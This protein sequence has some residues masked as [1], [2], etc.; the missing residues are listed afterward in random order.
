MK[1][2]MKL[3]L[4]GALGL[5]WAS[6]AVYAQPE[7]PDPVPP[8]APASQPAGF[9]PGQGILG[10][11]DKYDANKDGV[12]DKTEMVAFKKD[13]EDGKL[14]PPPGVRGMGG[15]GGQLAPGAGRLPKDILDKYDANKDGVL[16]E[17]E[18]AALHKDIQDGKIERP[19]AGDQRRPISPGRAA[20][21]GAPGFGQMQPPSPQEILKRFDADKDGKLDEKE[22][23]AF[24]KDMQKHRPM[25]RGP[26]GPGG[27]PPGDTPAPP[28]PPEQ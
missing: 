13:I 25:M 6:T 12:L 11:L 19:F 10:L 22:L 4:I 16:D 21:P 5:T 2:T 9:R 27:P 26:R 3:A 23:A 15:F 8:N 18:R 17:T 1:R 24:L 14:I 20:G 28:P 7:P